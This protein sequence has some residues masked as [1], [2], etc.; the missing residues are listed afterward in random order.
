MPVGKVIEEIPQAKAQYSQLKSQLHIKYEDMEDFVY[1]WG[2]G[3]IEAMFLGHIAYAKN[4]KKKQRS[5]M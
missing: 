3:K 5:E 4:L 1:G 2:T